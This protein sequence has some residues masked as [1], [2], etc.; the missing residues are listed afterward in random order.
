MSSGLSITATVS[1]EWKR[2]MLIIIAVVTGMGGWFFFDGLV[3]YPRQ[4]Q[5]AAAYA[6]LI[7]SAAG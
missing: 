5:R 7:A 1:K 3:A 6:A 4:N 2:R